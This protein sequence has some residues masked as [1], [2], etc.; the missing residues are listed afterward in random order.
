MARWAYLIL[1]T[2]CAAVAAPPHAYILNCMGCHL[3][4]GEGRP[5]NVPRLKDRVGYYLQISGGREYL[6]QVPGAAQSLLSDAELAVTT[7][8]L[9]RNFA[10]RSMPAD[11]KDFTEQ[12][13]TRLRHHG[14]VDIDA[15]REALNQLV[16]Q[17]EAQAILQ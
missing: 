1:L 12:E 9:V 10:G 7:N 16:D 5:P 13:V 14:P 4:Q 3:E 8:W 2:S 15:E 11:F 17:M 6:V